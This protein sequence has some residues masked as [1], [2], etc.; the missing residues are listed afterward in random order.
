MRLFENEDIVAL[1]KPPG[2]SMATSSRPE[3]S[4]AAAVARLLEACG[5]EPSDTR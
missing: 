2:V 5:E 1:D 3:K 4:G